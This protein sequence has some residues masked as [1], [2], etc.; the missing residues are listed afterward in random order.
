MLCRKN[1]SICN[2]KSSNDKIHPYREPFR[3][4]HI[5]AKPCTG[6]IHDH[7]ASLVSQL[8][9]CSYWCQPCNF[10]LS[11]VICHPIPLSEEKKLIGLSFCCS[12][13]SISVA[14]CLWYV[15]ALFLLK[16]RSNLCMNEGWFMVY[17]YN[18][19][20]SY[21]IVVYTL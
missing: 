21:P 14:I 3:W 8:I 12:Y 2:K 16:L 10:F 1:P 9:Y 17:N 7:I 11:L 19:C 20:R 15:C 5:L 4:W 13:V 18:S 6:V